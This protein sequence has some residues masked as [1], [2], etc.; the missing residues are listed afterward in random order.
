VVV[1]AAAIVAASAAAI[2][3][4]TKPRIKCYTFRGAF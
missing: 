3:A 4:V 2:V 1:S